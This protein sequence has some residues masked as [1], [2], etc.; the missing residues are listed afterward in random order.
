MD[1]CCIFPFKNIEWNASYMGDGVG[2]YPITI[3]I[4]K[5][6][7][8]FPLQEKLKKKGYN[9]CDEET[10]DNIQIAIVSWGSF[11]KHSQSTNLMN[12]L[13]QYIMMLVLHG[14]LSR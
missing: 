2:S 3:Y 10:H 6:E 12:T 8:L 9:I 11:S 7:T 14:R 13:E 1:A 4:N 5:P